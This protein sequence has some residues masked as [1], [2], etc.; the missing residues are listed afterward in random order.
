[1]KLSTDPQNSPCL[2]LTQYPDRRS[3]AYSIF[4]HGIV[5]PVVFTCLERAPTDK[6]TN[7][8]KKKE[9]YLV[10]KNG[11][12]SYNNYSNKL[13]KTLRTFYQ[14]WSKVV[15]DKEAVF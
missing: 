14:R 6:K 4:C 15:H 8:T 10:L 2:I 13:F 7:R 11:V 12:K 3:N 1:M 9:T 5:K